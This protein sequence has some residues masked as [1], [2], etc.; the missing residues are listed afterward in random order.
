MITS[1]DFLRLTRE[2]FANS[3]TT[4][5]PMT[6]P[7]PQPNYD[8]PSSETQTTPDT[9]TTGIEVIM[10]PRRGKSQKRQG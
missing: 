9:N 2:A 8:G 6:G 4:E 7:G 5:I 1:E 3:G 10:L